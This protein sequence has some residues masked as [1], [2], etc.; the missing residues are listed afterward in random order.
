LKE[1]KSDAEL[2]E[3][4]FRQGQTHDPLDVK[5]PTEKTVQI[6]FVDQLDNELKPGS[7]LIALD[8]W[9]D[10]GLQVGSGVFQSG[11]IFGIRVLEYILPPL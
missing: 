2:I 11:T 9:C 8:R 5:Y 7:A 10:N 1:Q 6:T 4:L 3:N